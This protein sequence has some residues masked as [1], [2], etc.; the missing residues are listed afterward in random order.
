MPSCRGDSA[1][2][3]T[4]AECQVS[5]GPWKILALISSKLPMNQRSVMLLGSVP[6]LL[7]VTVLRTSVS[8]AGVFSV[9]GFLLTNKSFDKLSPFPLLCSFTER[10]PA[11]VSFHAEVLGRNAPPSDTEVVDKPHKVISCLCEQVQ[12]ITM[13]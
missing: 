8:S 5:T 4:T 6:F 1:L 11:S 13:K 7:R 12:T 3:C 2:C 10:W 9:G